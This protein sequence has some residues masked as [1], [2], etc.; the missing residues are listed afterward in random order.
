[1]GF[2]YQVLFEFSIMILALTMGVLALRTEMKLR[3]PLF[4]K[5]IVA[6]LATYLLFYLMGY[7]VTFWQKH[8]GIPQNNTFIMNIHLSLESTLLIAAAVLYF[9]ERWK[10]NLSICLWIIFVVIHLAQISINGI[11][12]YSHYSDL[13]ACFI[14]SFLY[15][16]ILY[17]AF[18]KPGQ[19]WFRSPEVIICIGILAYY[20]SSIP[21]IALM[22]YLQKSYPKVNETLF[23]V[24]NGVLA[25]LRYLSVAIAFW[26]VRRN[27]LTC[28]AAHE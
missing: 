25:N 1:M 26:L 20:A 16:L 10:K 5:I 19:P 23:N 22:G 8:N 15:V 3:I 11:V 14:I 4:Q 24:I 9:T 6:Q 7:A 13:A 12:V 17:E 28:A 2:W 27:N 18:S 21:Y